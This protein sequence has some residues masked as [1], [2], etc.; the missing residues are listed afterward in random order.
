MCF[1]ATKTCTQLFF[2][3]VHIYVHILNNLKHLLFEYI[4][5]LMYMTKMNFQQHYSSLQCHTILQKSI[6]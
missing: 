3:E 6:K 2:W 4:L 1:I 5:K